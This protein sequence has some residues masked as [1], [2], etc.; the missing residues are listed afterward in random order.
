MCATSLDDVATT[1]AALQLSKAMS[2]ISRLVCS[3]RRSAFDLK[4]VLGFRPTAPAGR[5]P[6]ESG[7]APERAGWL[8]ERMAEDLS[9]FQL[10]VRLDAP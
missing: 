3:I 10:P 1:R 4:P 6:R 2:E 9:R 7:V 8:S 5:F